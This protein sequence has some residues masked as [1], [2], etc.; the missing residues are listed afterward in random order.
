M[1]GTDNTEKN[2]PEEK[3]QVSEATESHKKETTEENK[4][5]P[6][7][8]VKVVNP[9]RKLMKYARKELPLFVVGSIAL[10]GGSVGELVNPIYIGWFVDNLNDREYDMVYT[11]CWQ[12]GVIVV[13]SERNAEKLA[14]QVSLLRRM[15][16]EIQI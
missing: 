1:P 7:D 12:L 11:L 14:Y 10:L 5:A 15:L 3:K 9:T 4:V 8:E 16:K 2:R 6:Q 13:V